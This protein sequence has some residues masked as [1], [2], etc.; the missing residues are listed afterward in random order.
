MCSIFSSIL[1]EQVVVGRNFDWIQ[2]G[3]NLHFLPSTRLYGITTYPLCLIEQLGIDRPFE[4]FNSQGLFMGMTGVH[5]DLF[6]QRQNTNIKIKFDEFG[7]IKFILERAST[8]QE[9]IE[10]LDRVEV[11]PH[12]VEPYLRLQYFIVDSSGFF[13]IVSGQEEASIKHLGPQEFG[14]LTNFPLSLKDKISCDRFSTIEHQISHIDDERKA[15]AL[16]EQVSQEKFTIYS[17]L[18]YLNEKIINICIERD[19][20]SVLEFYLDKETSGGSKLYS[21][22]QIRLMSPHNRD[23]FKINTY[24]VQS[25][26]FD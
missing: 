6:S 20:Q 16:I 17:C 9:A 4:G 15:M 5:S 3:G 19:F 25:G 26:L 1:N 7:I 11:I 18:Y 23:R 14:I 2:F 12:G 13:C 10:I 24:E 21:F 8:T 22:S